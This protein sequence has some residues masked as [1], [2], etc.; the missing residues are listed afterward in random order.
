VNDTITFFEYQEKPKNELIAYGLRERDFRKIKI[1]NIKQK[2]TILKVLDDSVK[3]MSFVGFLSVGKNT[4]QILPKISKEYKENE[5]VRNLL[6]MLSFT[7]KLEIKETEISKLCKRKENNLFEIFVYLFSKNLMEII[8]RNFHR[9]YNPC[10]DDLCFIK[11]KISFTENLRKNLVRKHKLHCIYSEFTENILLN[12]IFRYTV[13]LLLKITKD[14]ENYRLL[15]QLELIFSDITLKR[16]EIY[17]FDKVHLNRLNRY[18]EPL[19]NLS[20]LF[21][22]HG[23]IQLFHDRLE[24]FSFVFDMEKLFE[25]FVAEFIK[26][27]KARLFPDNIRIKPHDATKKLV[28]APK[29]L[30]TLIPDIL[31]SSKDKKLI[32]DTKY[33]LLDKE[34]AKNGVSQSDMYQM[35]A[36]A[37]KH[38][39]KDVVLLYP[40]HH[41]IPSLKH[42]IK[43]NGGT[44]YVHIETIP[45][46]INMICE[47]ELL[48]KCLEPICSLVY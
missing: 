11:G 43:F 6:F 38:G 31:I 13:S 40:R 21:I 16:I 2:R 23:S 35:L 36:Y 9:N 20:K 33:K 45:L 27:N 10:E 3:A 48:L 41:N 18:Y 44:I 7:R 5:I 37:L 46:D 1:L 32:I 28:E 8:K 29:P 30:F 15:K 42:T 19:I 47:R 39:C 22:S 12:Q 17:D 14:R 4:I 34:D 25:E 24:T 26:R